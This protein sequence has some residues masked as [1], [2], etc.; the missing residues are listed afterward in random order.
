MAVLVDHG[1]PGASLFILFYVW[2]LISSCRL[3]WLVSSPD[4]AGPDPRIGLY[5][6]A[7][8]PAFVAYLTV[9]QF[10]NF[11]KAE[12]QIWLLAFLVVFPE[13]YRNAIHN[14]SLNLIK[15]E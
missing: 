14:D 13:I 12:I 10:T 6:A 4:K 11:F 7:L 2:A 15:A 5:A 1:I 8:G 9:A 3:R